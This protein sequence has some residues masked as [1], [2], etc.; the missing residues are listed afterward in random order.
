M[1]SAALSLAALFFLA[2]TRPV[3]AVFVAFF[4]ALEKANGRAGE[5]EGFPKPIFE[6]ALVAEVQA[7]I[8]VREKNEGGRRSA[9][10]RD[11]VNLDLARSRRGTTFEVHGRD[12][13]V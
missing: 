4:Y 6:E 10:L 2:A 1:G 13:A 11:V 9:G 8:L 3:E 7:L 5:V 12:P